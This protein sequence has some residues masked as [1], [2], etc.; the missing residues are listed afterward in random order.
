M[1]ECAKI[2]Q[3]LV[4]ELHLSYLVAGLDCPRALKMISARPA[5]FTDEDRYQVGKC[6]YNTGDFTRSEMVMRGLLSRADLWKDVRVKAM[7]AMAKL[8]A[9]SHRPEEARR[10]Y[11]R[12]LADDP[13]SME[14][15]CYIALLDVEDRVPLTAIDPVMRYI[16]HTQ[17]ASPHA[18]QCT[19]IYAR[20]VSISPDA[21][22][23]ADLSCMQMFGHPKSRE[24]A[25]SCWAE[26]IR[27]WFQEDPLR[28]QAE[29][30]GLNAAHE[31][32][33]LHDIRNNP[34]DIG[35]LTVFG[36]FLTKNS[37]PWRAADVFEVVA[38]RTADP[39]DRAK[40]LQKAASNYFLAGA[41]ELAFD[42]WRRLG[43]IPG[44][45]NQY[46][47]GQA[48]VAIA[49]MRFMDAMDILEQARMVP[50]HLH[51][52]A[53]GARIAAFLS[54]K[55]YARVGRASAQAIL[56]ALTWCDDHLKLY[57]DDDTIW[58]SAEYVNWRVRESLHQYD[59]IVSE[60]TDRLIN[61][62][63]QWNNRLAAVYLTYGALAY[64]HRGKGFL[65]RA[66]M[67]IQAEADFKK[68]DDLLMEVLAQKDGMLKSGDVL[69]IYNLMEAWLS[70]GWSR[71]NRGDYDGA[72]A[73]FSAVVNARDWPRQHI[74]PKQMVEAYRGVTTSR[75]RMARRHFHNRALETA[76]K[77]S[78][79][80]VKSLEDGLALEGR[81]LGVPAPFRHP[82]NFGIVDGDP[83][84]LREE[85]RAIVASGYVTYIHYFDRAVHAES[86]FN[87]AVAR[88]WHAKILR[89]WGKMDRAASEYDRAEKELLEVLQDAPDH[90]ES[91]RFLEYIAVIH[92]GD[93]DKA[94]SYYNEAVR[95]E[96]EEPMDALV[97]MVE[98]YDTQIRSDARLTVEQVVQRNTLRVKRLRY[99]ARLADMG[100]DPQQLERAL[101]F[102][103]DLAESVVCEEGST[104]R[105]QV[106]QLMQGWLFVP[107]GLLPAQQKRVVRN[108]GRLRAIL[109]PCLQV[110]DI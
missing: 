67:K 10:Y 109:A 48:L 101:G 64:M 104:Y 108:H 30:N 76:E 35:T 47:V 24:Y 74:L 77:F 37:Q 11:E 80:A 22:D 51:R 41:P 102:A 4:P 50:S 32:V 96:T 95:C 78:A 9:N 73:I 21:Q 15:L 71:Y 55:D 75:D 110:L 107:P 59:S 98:G 7:Y 88:Y 87:L 81:F 99:A 58:H 97:K 57:P 46:I 17:S 94:E 72:D 44:Y 61:I 82:L 29:L 33:L 3:T 8:S 20:T 93:M 36:N 89:E 26:N 25:W 5:E 6:F 100:R 34:R 66:G 53:S 2:T 1:D 14:S 42:V 43:A 18:L 63:R 39:T 103:R 92:K 65:R 69:N 40:A 79:E 105:S 31:A 27:K 13:T 12:V 84:V 56:Q 86:M 45:D 83:E 49:Q 91:Y 28:V 60:R 19:A 52:L 38:N 54:S 90:A 23:M 62:G 16:L 70:L 106:Q 68:A 85:Q